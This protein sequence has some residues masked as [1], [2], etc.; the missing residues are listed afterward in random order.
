MKWLMLYVYDADL[1]ATPPKL[2][3]RGEIRFPVS[4]FERIEVRYGATEIKVAGREYFVKE[5]ADQLSDMVLAASGIL[6]TS[7][8]PYKHITGQ[9]PR[10][11]ECP[12]RD[13]LTCRRFYDGDS[14]CTAF[15]GVMK[16]LQ[17][18]A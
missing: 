4:S 17:H 7:N 12:S 18:N 11:G 8:E 9:L 1:S 5:S 14:R 16:C 3:S 10:L 13:G 2:F 15:G 6:D